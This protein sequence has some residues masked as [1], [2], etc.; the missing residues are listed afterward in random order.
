L[1]KF[2]ERI[3]G[4][5]FEAIFRDIQISSQIR[6][7]QQ[8]EVFLHYGAVR[9]IEAT[10][11]SAR[12][13][14]ERLTEKEA[15]VSLGGLVSQ[16]SRLEVDVEK[17]SGVEDMGGLIEFI[18]DDN[19]V[20]WDAEGVDY[21]NRTITAVVT[22]VTAAAAQEAKQKKIGAVVAEHIQKAARRLRMKPDFLC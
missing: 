9:V 16:L 1:S 8:A 2:Y 10:V 19:G 5:M 15:S 6:I 18:A 17:T 12:L 22:T 14:R 4:E 11:N 3:G 21:L 13:R 20:P 7:T